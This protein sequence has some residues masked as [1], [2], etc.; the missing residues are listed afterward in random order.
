MGRLNGVTVMRSVQ[1]QLAIFLSLG[2]EAI[3]RCAIH[4]PMIYNM[5]YHYSPQFY[6]LFSAV[7]TFL[8]Q[9]SLAEWLT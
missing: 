8:L 2:A 7:N 3:P 1:V 5:I 4:G 9:L 6:V